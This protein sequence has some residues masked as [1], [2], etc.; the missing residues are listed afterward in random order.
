MAARKAAKTAA[1]KR[2]RTAKK[3]RRSPR[4]GGRFVDPERD[5]TA[6]V[7]FGITPR[8]RK[9]LPQAVLQPYQDAYLQSGR[10][11]GYFEHQSIP[12]WISGP[13][14]ATPGAIT[15]IWTLDD[16]PAS[17]NLGG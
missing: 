16:I 7:L 2:T 5:P 11:N 14:R 8:V 3:A 10:L 17:V 15:Q 13:Y 12:F 6:P 4:R 1:K 9:L